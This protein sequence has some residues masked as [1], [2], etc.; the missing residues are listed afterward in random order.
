MPARLTVTPAVELIDT[1]RV[2]TLDG[3][4]PHSRVTLTVTSRQLDGQR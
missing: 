3:F 4:H 2:F 1:P